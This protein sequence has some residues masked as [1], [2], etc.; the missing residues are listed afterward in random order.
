MLA[1]SAMQSCLPSESKGANETAS[2]EFPLRQDERCELCCRGPALLHRPWGG[3]LAVS[4]RNRRVIWSDLFYSYFPASA[5]EASEQRSIQRFLRR[6]E[7]ALKL[8]PGLKLKQ[9]PLT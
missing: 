2:F 5:H 7:G 3:P 9:L 1:R 6:Q 8:P 4:F